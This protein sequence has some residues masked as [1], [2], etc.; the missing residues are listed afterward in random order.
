[1]SKLEELKHSFSFLTVEDKEKLNDE[2]FARYYDDYKKRHTYFCIKGI[3]FD[4]L[5][6]VIGLRIGDPY[7]RELMQLVRY[8]F[9]RFV[10]KDDGIKKISGYA[11]KI[12]KV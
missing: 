9:A 6:E 10:K 1:M 8:R 4:Y 7:V 5:A 3:A 12:I 2:L 11:Y